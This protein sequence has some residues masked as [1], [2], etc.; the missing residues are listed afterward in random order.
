VVN[1]VL[2]IVSGNPYEAIALEFI[3]QLITTGQGWW[4][5]SKKAAAKS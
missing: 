2:Q 3:N 4:R 1:V 5:L